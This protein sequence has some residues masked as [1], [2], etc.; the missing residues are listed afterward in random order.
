MLQVVVPLEAFPDQALAAHRTNATGSIPSI[1]MLVM[2]GRNQMCR[3]HVI[4]GTI[5]P[6]QVTTR[7]GRSSRK[8]VEGHSFMALRGPVR[9]EC[10]HLLC[11]IGNI[12][13]RCCL[14]ITILLVNHYP[15]PTEILTHELDV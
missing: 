5:T 9:G 4:V 13:G 10:P 3:Q 7:D 11:L 6:S 12:R 15:N 1:V 8:Q 14:S 2:L